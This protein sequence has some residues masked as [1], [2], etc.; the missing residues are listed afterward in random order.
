VAGAAI[1]RP[2]RIG[3]PELGR[4]RQRW[5]ENMQSLAETHDEGFGGGPSLKK[6]KEKT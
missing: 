5:T 6:E 2:H 4:K 1:P 3:E